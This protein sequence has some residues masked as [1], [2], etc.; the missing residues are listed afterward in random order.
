MTGWGVGCMQWLGVTALRLVSLDW[1]NVRPMRR[2]LLR[3][4][5]LAQIHGRYVPMLPALGDYRHRFTVVFG[6]NSHQRCAPLGRKRNS[7]SDT[8]LE[9]RRMRLRLLQEI[10]S[11]D[12][13]VVQINKLIFAKPVYVDSHAYLRLFS[14]DAPAT[15][16]VTPNN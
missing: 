14:C 15:S 12:N 4:T 10:Q 1:H 11:G 6:E 7:I 3:G 2:I 5:S 8:K 13:S 16:P 9:H